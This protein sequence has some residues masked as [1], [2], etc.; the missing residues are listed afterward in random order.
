MHDF[1]YDSGESDYK[2]FRVVF[3]NTSAVPY[4][5][6]KAVDWCYNSTNDL[7]FSNVKINDD[8]DDVPNENLIA[9]FDGDYVIGVIEE[10]C[11]KK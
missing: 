1:M 6:V 2:I 3:A 5:D 9:T 10:E 4:I 8:E 7:Q 11:I